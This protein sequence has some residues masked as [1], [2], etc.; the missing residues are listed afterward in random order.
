MNNNI[1]TYGS[2]R[3]GEYN[4]DRFPGLKWLGTYQLQGYKLYSLGPYPGIKHTG[5]NTDLLTV[6][7][8]DCGSSK[9]KETIDNMELGAGYSKKELTLESGTKG[10]LYLYD[11]NI[12]E[13]NLVPSGDW[14]KR[15]ENASIEEEG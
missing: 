9:T 1:I 4:F 14:T 7:L 2:L 13:S 3:K 8:I 5:N 15:H 11:G 6:D 12:N 10:T